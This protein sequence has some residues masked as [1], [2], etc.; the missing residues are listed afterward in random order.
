MRFP[1]VL[2]H[3]GLEKRWTVYLFSRQL[4]IETDLE[5]VDQVRVFLL[6]PRE[7]GSCR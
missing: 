5:Q 2:W 1:V 4:V 3:Q 7:Y 6:Q